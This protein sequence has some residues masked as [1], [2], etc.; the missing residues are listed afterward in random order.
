MDTNA[1]PFL[2]AILLLKF[3]GFDL[4]GEMI[5]IS[6]SFG[7]SLNISKH[8]K[9]LSVFDWHIYSY[10]TSN[11]WAPKHVTPSHVLHNVG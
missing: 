1:L 5:C 4:I 8:S 2:K 7:N 11:L 3:I 6:G 9:V 10:D